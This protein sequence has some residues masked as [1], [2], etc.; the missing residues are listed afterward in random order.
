MG[1]VPVFETRRLILRE[2]R[3]SDAPSYERHFVDYEVI[4]QLSSAVPWPYPVGGVKDYLSQNLPK[5][6]LNRWDWAICLKENPEEV[7][8]SV[9]LWRP[10][11]PEHRGFWLGKKFWGQGLMTEAVVPVNDY[12]FDVLGFEKL[13]FSNA[14]GNLRSRRV[15]EK[16]GAKLIGTRPAGFVNPSYTEAETWELSK[17]DWSSFK[18]RGEMSPP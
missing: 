10:G 11:T 7:I 17:E 3:L 6:G 15:K 14:V 8:G 9:G 5:Q 18:A 1:A 13:I 12:A 4:S 16:T 2:L